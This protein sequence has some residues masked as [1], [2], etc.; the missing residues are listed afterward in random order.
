[1]QK[2]TLPASSA[3]KEAKEAPAKDCKASKARSKAQLQLQKHQSTPDELADHD[4]PL[5]V[6]QS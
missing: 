6:R 5:N 1:M 4:V 3:T 2:A